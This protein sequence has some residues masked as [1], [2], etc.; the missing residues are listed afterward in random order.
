MDT[1]TRKALSNRKGMQQQIMPELDDIF[2]LLD[3]LSEQGYF[4]NIVLHFENGHIP[5]IEKNQSIKRETIKKQVAK[6]KSK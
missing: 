3:K 4:G 6:F 2:E 5:R 1:R